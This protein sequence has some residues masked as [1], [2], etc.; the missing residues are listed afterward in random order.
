LTGGRSHLVTGLGPVRIV[1]VAALNQSGIDTMTIRPGKLGLLRGVASIA[2]VRLWFHQQEIDI[3]GAVGTV[4]ACATDAVGEVFGL[5]EVLGLQAGLVA[6]R[7]NGNCLRRTQRFEANN[8]C[9]V[10]AAVHMR[11]CGAMASL[12]TVLVSLEQRRVRRTGKM[13]LP[14]LL[15]AGFADV[16]VSVLAIARTGKRG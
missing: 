14:D 2:Q 12:A 5:G 15:M 16:G 6:L 8:L 3:L 13:L 4:A 7:A 10:A 1:T 9:D 11:L